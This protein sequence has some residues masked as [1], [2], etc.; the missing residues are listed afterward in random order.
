[1]NE[2][3]HWM[4]VCAAYLTLGEKLMLSKEAASTMQGSILHE[5]LSRAPFLTRAISES[6]DL[7]INTTQPLELSFCFL[8]L[9]PILLRRSSVSYL[10]HSGQLRSRWL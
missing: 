1:M 3:C 6:C 8:Y 10:V 9:S 5:Y 4:C 7:N 2:I